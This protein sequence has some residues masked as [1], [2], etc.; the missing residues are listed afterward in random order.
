MAMSRKEESIF[1]FLVEHIEALA[2]LRSLY[3]L[4]HMRIYHLTLDEISLIVV[5]DIRSTND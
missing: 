1:F 2:T 4:S 3:I 5:E